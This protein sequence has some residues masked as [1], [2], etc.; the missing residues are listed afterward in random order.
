MP[1]EVSPKNK[2]LTVVLN[3]LAVLALGLSLTGWLNPPAGVALMGAAVG[4]WLWEILALRFTAR[5]IASPLHRVLIGMGIF[6][7]IAAACWSPIFKRLHSQEQRMTIASGG[8]QDSKPAETKPEDKKSTD[9][10]KDI[11]P[12]KK[13]NGKKPKEESAQS[14]SATAP[15]EPSA[16]PPQPN[17]T[18]NNAPSGIANS[19]TIQGNATVNNIGTSREIT[20]KA[21]NEI[22]ASLSGF[23]KLRVLVSPVP[24]DGEEMNLVVG[25]ENALSEA[26]LD[27]SG[28]VARYVGASTVVGV[29]VCPVPSPQDVKAAQLLTDILNRNGVDASINVGNCPPPAFS[30][31]TNI[32]VGSIPPKQQ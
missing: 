2:T 25:I 19:G 12:T 31:Y 11:P 18:V 21:A 29:L 24:G 26:G 8:T 14:P 13:K 28:G 4:H 3:G 7:I 20:S 22:R 1:E 10:K 5:Y 27:V 17:V 23:P 9:E 30:G 15:K 16:K 32:L 6:A